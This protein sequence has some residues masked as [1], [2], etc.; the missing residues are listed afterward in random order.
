MSGITSDITSI[1]LVYKY[2]IQYFNKY[3]IEIHFHYQLQIPKSFAMH[4]YASV[5]ECN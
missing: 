1:D 5:M 4:D 2:I 3:I